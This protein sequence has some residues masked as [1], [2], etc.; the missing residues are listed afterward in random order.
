MKGNNRFFEFL[1]AKGLVLILFLSFSIRIAFYI[2]LQPWS[3]E[4]VN[5][6]I[7]I[8][9]SPTYHNLALSLVSTQT[10]E[11][12]DGYR[13]PG[14]PVFLAIFY[15]LIPNGV[16]LVLLCQVI[17]SVASAYLVYRIASLFFSKNI[18]LFAAFLFSIDY[19][20]I[21]SAVQLMSD[22][23][24]VFL[25]L[26]SILFLCRFILLNNIYWLIR[27]SVL[28]GLSALVRP[29]SYL[30]P[31]VAVLLFIFV[32]RDNYKKKLFCSVLYFVIFALILLT[33]ITRNYTKY[34]EASLTSI[35]GYNL[36]FYNVASVESYKSKK[37]YEEVKQDLYNLAVKNGCDPVDSNSSFDKMQNYFM[38]ISNNDG[39]DPVNPLSSFKNS[40]IYTK[41]STDYIK[42]NFALYCIRNVYGIVYMYCAS[43]AG[44]ILQDFHIS[45]KYSD[46]IS[47]NR[48]TSGFKYSDIFRLMSPIELIIT[49]SGII[50]LFFN[51]SLS[52]Y[53]IVLSIKKK[54][55]LI[56]I[57]VSL[58]LILY[59]T[60][61]TG[62]VGSSRYRMPFMPF[63]NILC[64]AGLAH[65]FR[66]R[67]E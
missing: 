17:I 53:N 62:I 46:Y 9:D 56:F 10:F 16:W 33:W 20:Q 43:P 7:S 22:T 51:Y 59:F 8:N 40:R 12:F 25:F 14:Y 29:I 30:F 38:H 60:A 5:N 47:G 41:I 58:L 37:P 21:I 48:L 42:K 4:F 63:I 50:F 11:Y 67:S 64:A 27:S 57:A 32:L 65:L 6:T 39:C 3:S 26:A 1:N 13:T 44:A 31:V 66:M 61:L 34:G 23:L 49:F 36:L 52:L 24:F 15:A 2:S 18:S 45:S 19:I 28:L 54:D 35:S 55:N